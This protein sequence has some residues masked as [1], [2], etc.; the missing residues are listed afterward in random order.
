MSGLPYPE[1]APVFSCA[2]ALAFEQARFS[3]PNAEAKEWE[4]MQAAGAGVG[5]GILRDACEHGGL[6]PGARILVLV[7]KGTTAG[8]R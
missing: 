6:Q 5:D 3:G 2:E 7:G 4:A 8:T 1:S